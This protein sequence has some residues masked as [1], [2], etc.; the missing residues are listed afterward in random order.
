VRGGGGETE[1]RKSPNN[2]VPSGTGLF[3]LGSSLSLSLSLSP[4]SLYSREQGWVI[5]L[6]RGLVGLFR[7]EGRLLLEQLDT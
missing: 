3:H 5:A 6:R 1:R 4:L 2:D 7:I